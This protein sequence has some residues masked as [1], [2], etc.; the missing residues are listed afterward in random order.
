MR[1]ETENTTDAFEPGSR[2]D[3]Q[4][5]SGSH[6]AYS[7][8]RCALAHLG[9][10]EPG[11]RLVGVAYF[12]T[13]GYWFPIAPGPRGVYVPRSFSDGT[14]AILDGAAVAERVPAMRSVPIAVE[15]L[16]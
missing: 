14:A 4:P 9:E 10:S 11:A 8:S 15:L 7:A 2:W 3:A 1:D 16:G 12:D 13:D 5:M 6:S